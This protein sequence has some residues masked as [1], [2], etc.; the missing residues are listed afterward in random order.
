MPN[1]DEIRTL[2]DRGMDILSDLTV[3]VTEEE[4]DGEN[5]GKQRKDKET[6]WGISTWVKVRDIF[7]RIFGQVAERGIIFV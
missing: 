1:G 6:D 3:V 2:S 5:K 7:V 4:L